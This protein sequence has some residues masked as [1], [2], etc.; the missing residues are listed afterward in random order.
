MVYLNQSL[1]ELQIKTLRVNIPAKRNKPIKERPDIRVGLTR[2]RAVGYDRWYE[3]SQNRINFLQG[4]YAKMFSITRNGSV[5]RN[6]KPN[7]RAQLIPRQRKDIEFIY[8]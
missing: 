8:T 4:N 3:D 2:G 5:V 1:E 6:V 7:I